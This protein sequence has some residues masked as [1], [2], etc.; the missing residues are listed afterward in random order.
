M[1]MNIGKEV[2]ALKRMTVAELRG[3]Y[4]EV[5]GEETRCRQK[6]YLVRRITW[7]LQANQE[8]DISERARKRAEELAMGA[9][10]R[11][12]PPR[13]KADPAN[14]PTRTGTVLVSQDDRLPMPGAVITREYKGEAIEVRVLP[15]GFEYEGEFYRTLSAV[16]KKVTGTHWNGYHFFRLGKK[17][18]GDGQ[19]EE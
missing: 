13:E 1:V 3:R 8:G 15:D 18:G 16:A 9:D 19:Q 6:D 7:R 4:A 2:A 5:T 11:L 12:T 10:V 14:G 17:G